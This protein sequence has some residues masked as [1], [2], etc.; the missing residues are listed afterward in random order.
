MNF[1]P[2]STMELLRWQ[3]GKPVL[4]NEACNE[5]SVARG[6]AEMARQV[7]T[8]DGT[9][10]LP[11]LCSPLLKS[12][13][14]IRWLL[15]FVSSLPFSPSKSV[16]HPFLLPLSYSLGCISREAPWWY[17]W[18]VSHYGPSL[19]SWLDLHHPRLALCYCSADW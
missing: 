1:I 19:L 5:I 8:L 9:T 13:F 7:N 4:K 6:P 10:N 17:L 11:T 16:S 18:N 2:G 15:V 3:I 12:L 14:F